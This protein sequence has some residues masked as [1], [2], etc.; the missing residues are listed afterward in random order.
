ML[1]AIELVV[2]ALAG[3]QMDFEASSLFVDEG[4]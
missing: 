4:G 1:P 3:T 2:T